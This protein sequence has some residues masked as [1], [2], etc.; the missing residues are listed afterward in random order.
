MCARSQQ[1]V[2]SRWLP[3]PLV[4]QR[5]VGGGRCGT[6]FMSSLFENLGGGGRKLNSR[7]GKDFC[8]Q[9]RSVYQSA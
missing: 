4:L 5:K 2:G 1:N 9:D 7:D 6:P 3:D 8:V